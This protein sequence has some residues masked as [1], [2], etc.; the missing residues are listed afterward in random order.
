MQATD[1]YTF[2]DIFF[3][4]EWRVGYIIMKFSLGR[5]LFGLYISMFHFTLVILVF[6]CIF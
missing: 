2:Y 3:L 6:V 1:V 5:G 4:F